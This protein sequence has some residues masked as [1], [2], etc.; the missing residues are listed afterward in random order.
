M[1][2]KIDKER[3]G[4]ERGE[5]KGSRWRDGGKVIVIG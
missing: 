2:R 3:R 5:R 4:R 1:E